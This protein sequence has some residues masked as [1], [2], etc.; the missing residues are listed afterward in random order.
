VVNISVFAIALFPDCGAKIGG[1]F[2]I[3][4]YSSKKIQM[5]LVKCSYFGFLLFDY[6]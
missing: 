3:A 4:K 6:Q 2:E 5:A 1:I